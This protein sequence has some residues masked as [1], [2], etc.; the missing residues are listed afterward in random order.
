ML[1]IQSVRAPHGEGLQE[2]PG[3][4][5]FLLYRD[6]LTANWSADHSEAMK[7][8]PAAAVARLRRRDRLSISVRE[9]RTLLGEML[10]VFQLSGV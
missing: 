1:T 3:S 7:C 2:D 9:L 5:V 8:W 6:D 4:W 10:S